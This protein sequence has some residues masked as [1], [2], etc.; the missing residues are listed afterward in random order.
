MIIKI[1]VAIP[2]NG[3]FFPNEM[4]IAFHEGLP[5]IQS[6]NFSDVSLKS[7]QLK[8]KVIFKCLGYKFPKKKIFITFTNPNL[9][10]SS[11]QY[12]EVP[13]MAAVFEYLN[14]VEFPTDAFFSGSLDL[15][16]CFQLSKSDQEKYQ[17]FIDEFCEKLKLFYP[18]DYKKISPEIFKLKELCLSQI[19]VNDQAIHLP[20]MLIIALN[21]QRL[22]GVNILLVDSG[23]NGNLILDK[24]NK[25]K[26]LITLEPENFNFISDFTKDILL[27]N[28]ADASF[29]QLKNIKKSNFQ[30]TIGIVKPCPCGRLLT[31][32][33]CRCG[34]N[35]TKT[36][37]KNF[38]P[39]FFSKFQIIIY[40]DDNLLQSPDF[41]FQ[42]FESNF[43]FMQYADL[44]QKVD[45][46][47]EKWNQEAFFPIFLDTDRKYLLSSISQ[48]EN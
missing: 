27:Q 21:I 13:L 34:V 5:F 32:K 11:Y 45:L 24:I 18:G 38:S 4:Q 23:L 37:Y 10:P 44:N 3:K 36:F 39:N 42:W 29:S 20:R 22:L 15:T 30:S 19:S 47:L 43:D 35:Y 14:L 16:G 2:I 12:L 40:L 33:K 48:I 41:K 7:L 9:I 46:M 17:T 8:L 31:T 6:P 1:K 26:T 25:I 28:I